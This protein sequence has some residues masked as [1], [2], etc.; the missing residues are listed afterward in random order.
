MKKTKL[1]L[2]N[3]IVPSGIRGE[4]L[5]YQPSLDGIRGISIIAVVL[6][7]LGYFK[8]GYLG[9]QIFFVLSGFLISQILIR[10]EINKNNMLRFILRRFA[11]L[12]PVLWLSVLVGSLIIFVQYGMLQ[13][14]YPLRA[15][16]YLRNFFPIDGGWHD[17]WTPTWSLAAE[18]QFYII[19]P[20]TLALA[21]KFIKEHMVP[22][23]YLS[24]YIFIKFISVQ[25]L[26]IDLPSHVIVDPSAIAL[27]CFLGLGYFRETIS[28]RRIDLILYFLLGLSVYTASIGTTVEVVTALLILNLQRD[29][30]IIHKF[31]SFKPIVW[32]GLLSYSIYIWQGLL[33][34]VIFSFFGE[35]PWIY[36]SIFFTIL[37]FVST[38]SFYVFEIPSRNW[39]L[40]KFYK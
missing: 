31:F 28:R 14:Q 20:I 39:I 18:E 24:Y 12:I 40:R 5:S 9:V 11:R 8:S 3:F 26:G 13:L 35:S 29:K 16:L 4:S 34:P 33:I 38:T 10:K 21:N 15:A 23:I 36:L 19:F 7:H 1:W 22:Y 30:N 17:I 32:V 37:L 27:G 6:F 2:K 25:I